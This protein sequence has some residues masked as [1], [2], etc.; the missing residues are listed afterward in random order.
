MKQSFGSAW[1]ELS[2]GGHVAAS[3]ERLLLEAWEIDDVLRT[4]LREDRWLDGALRALGAIER[5]ADAFHRRVVH[6]LAIDPDVERFASAV[7]RKLRDADLRNEMAAKWRRVW[8]GTAVAALV[9]LAVGVALF[10]TFET[11]TPAPSLALA[12]HASGGVTPETVAPVLPAAG[13]I[14]FWIH[15]GWVPIAPTGLAGAAPTGGWRLRADAAAA[16]FLLGDGT[17]VALRARSEVLVSP[18]RPGVDSAATVTLTSGSLFVRH[19]A[20]AGT[21]SIRTSQG[22]VRASRA[23]AAGFGVQQTQSGVVVGVVYGAVQAA[24]PTDVLG[25]GSGLASTLQASAASPRRPLDVSAAFAWSASTE[26]RREALLHFDFDD[27]R[28]PKPWDAAH[29]VRCPPRRNASQGFCLGAQHYDVAPWVVGVEM[30]DQKA[31]LFTHERGAILAFDYWV[32]QGAVGHEQRLE[33]WLETGPGRTGGYHYDIEGVESAQWVHVEIPLDD[34]RM[35]KDRNRRIGAGERID[36][37]SMMVHWRAE[38]IL[39]LD[40]VEI[41]RS[42]PPVG[43]VR[44]DVTPPGQPGLHSGRD[45]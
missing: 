29:V 42:A 20:D 38:D 27:G 35:N 32:G 10:L 4:Q 13:S 21:F 45:R 33:V 15:E 24:T 1:A 26:V 16:A 7:D 5:D 34:F 22:E 44:S 30:N 14:E 2:C 41:L 19:P 18:P 3:E 40:N 17:R 8:G 11:R 25:I 39:F 31:G 37:L 28:A 23:G 43:D 36:F 12:P 9:G 6:A